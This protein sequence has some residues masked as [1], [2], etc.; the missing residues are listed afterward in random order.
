MRSLSLI[1]LGSR[2]SVNYQGSFSFDPAFTRCR[3]TS[4]SIWQMCTRVLRFQKSTQNGAATLLH[5]ER[6]RDWPEWEPTS[7][8]TLSALDQKLIEMLHDAAPHCRPRPGGTSPTLGWY[9]LTVKLVRSR[10]VSRIVLQQNFWW[11]NIKWMSKHY[12]LTTCQKFKKICETFLQE[13]SGHRF[14][15]G[16][17]AKITNFKWLYLSNLLTFLQTVFLFCPAW[18]LLILITFSDFWAK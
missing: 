6:A 16:P 2:K 3:L 5:L 9:A 13:Y 4:P 7:L 17:S 18:I 15:S 14:I 12:F 8:H 10:K 11:K 1:Q